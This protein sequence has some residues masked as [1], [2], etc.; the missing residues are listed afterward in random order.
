[1]GS[2]TEAI[3][4]LLLGGYTYF[5]LH[6]YTHYISGYLFNGS[7]IVHYDRVGPLPRP[8]AVSY[9]NLPN[10]PNIGVRVCGISPHIVWG[11]VTL[12][13]LLWIDVPEFSI[14]SA[15]GIF[16][17]IGEVATQIDP[18]KLYLLTSSSTASI[19]VSPS[20]LVAT[21][22]PQ[23]YREYSGEETTKSEYLSVLFTGPT[24]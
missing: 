22:R 10:M 14:N 19:S 16:L 20:D 12:L 21:F 9:Q 23:A 17:A 5:Y 6:E 1:M 4:V 18:W 13:T 3:V 2:A 8:Y 11:L 7:P 15:T 24:N